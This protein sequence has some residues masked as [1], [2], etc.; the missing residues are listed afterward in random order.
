M[1]ESLQVLANVKN[2]NF[3]ETRL[4]F[5]WNFLWSENPGKNIWNEVK[6]SCFSVLFN[7]HWQKL[8]F[9]KKTW[10]KAV[11]STQIWDFLL[12]F[13]NLLI[14]HVLSRSATRETLRMPSFLNE[15]SSF[16]IVV[17][18]GTS[19][20]TFDSSK[21]IWSKFSESYSFALYTSKKDS[22]S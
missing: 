11:L 9:G 6:T 21:I 7:C 1:E 13:P 15:I 18:S 5:A 14:S 10:H 4:N 12:F 19:T 8:T 16:V 3:E 22:S 2:W 20:K 17:A